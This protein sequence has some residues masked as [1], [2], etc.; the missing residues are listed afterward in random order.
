MSG[1]KA[2][3]IGDLVLQRPVIQ[4]GMGVGISLHK[5]AGAVAASGGMGLIST[6]Q[7]GFRE[8]DFKTNFVEANLRAIRREMQKAREI[9]PKGAIGFNIMVATKHYPAQM[10]LYPAQVFRYVFR[11]M[12]RLLTKR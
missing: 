10:P 12:H 9:A 5:L 6:A 3:K 1:I 7:I 2:L 8:P 11:N 4:G